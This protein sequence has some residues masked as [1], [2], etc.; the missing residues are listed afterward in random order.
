[1]AK[2][3]SKLQVT[4]PKVLAKRF[5]IQPGD[6]IEWAAAGDAIRLV[7]AR[8]PA[9]RYSLEERLTLFDQATERQRA[10]QAN[11]AERSRPPARGWSRE[12]L[13]SRGGA[14]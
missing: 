11:E 9:A 10:R 13:Y 4:I 7:P 5:G 8:T 3:T 1:M 12:E 6:A 2:V 14:G